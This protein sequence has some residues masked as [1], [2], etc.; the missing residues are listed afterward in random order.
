MSDVELD[1]SALNPDER[2]ERAGLTP[3]EPASQLGGVQRVGV[4]GVAGK[5]RDGRELGRRHGIWLEGQEDAHRIHLAE[6]GKPRP[7]PPAEDEALA[8]R[9]ARELLRRHVAEGIAAND[10]P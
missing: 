10:A 3:G 1:V 2:V 4:A 7:G 8:R 5:V 9:Y 6:L